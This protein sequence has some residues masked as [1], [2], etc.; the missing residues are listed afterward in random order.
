MARRRTLDE[1]ALERVERM[2]L[3]VLRRGVRP[4]DLNPFPKF[5]L[6]QLEASFPKSVVQR[7]N[8]EFE[9]SEQDV[10]SPYY[11]AHTKLNLL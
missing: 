3:R 6:S 1:E 11:R 7:D 8:V 4:E 5:G 9:R 10:E 2:V